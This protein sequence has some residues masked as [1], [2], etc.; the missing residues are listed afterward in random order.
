MQSCSLCGAENPDGAERCG[1]CNADL[2]LGIPLEE[3]ETH[4]VSQPSPTPH[5]VLEMEDAGRFQLSKTKLGIFFAVLLVI[6][7][8]WLLMHDLFSIPPEVEA[9]R[10]E[11]L[12]SFENYL[13]NQ[14][15]WSQ[16]KQQILM[17]MKEHEGG[18]DLTRE[19]LLLHD[20]PVEVLFAYLCE[21]L[22]FSFSNY[23]EV[24]LYPLV[25]QLGTRMILS[26]VEDDMWPLKVLCSL[27]F[28]L[29]VTP[30]GLSVSF[31]RMRRGS[32]SVPTELAWGTFA[33]ELQNLRK[34]EGFSGGVQNFQIYS[35]KKAT[36]PS[37]SPLEVSMHYLHHPMQKPPV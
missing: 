17:R 21:D 29:E 20:L 10:K 26:K 27:E 33:E 35:K 19:T 16:Q 8:P 28:S 25:D 1:L 23:E 24:C 14:E 15:M 31:L 13:K 5:V 34:L 18:E 32:R 36:S 11:C 6:A 4:T 7:A 9:S 22:E 30:Q 2:E 12:V 3:G 37:T